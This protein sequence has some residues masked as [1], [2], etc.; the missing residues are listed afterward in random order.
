MTRSFA[1]QQPEE[2]AS[3]LDGRSVAVLRLLALVGAASCREVERQRIGLNSR[4][5]QNVM[6]RLGR[7]GLVDVAG[8]THVGRPARTYRLSKAGREVERLCLGVRSCASCGSA[9]GVDSGDG[10]WTC[11]QCGDEWASDADGDSDAS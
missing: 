1:R 10:W 9:E 7:Y 11:L 6:A 2:L 8:F 3:K 4:Q 5:A